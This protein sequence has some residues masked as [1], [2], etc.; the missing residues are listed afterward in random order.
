MGSTPCPQSLLSGRAL[1][2]HFHRPRH[3]ETTREKSSVHIKPF[4]RDGRYRRAARGPRTQQHPPSR[5]HP[6]LTRLAFVL[7][8]A[9]LCASDLAQAP[10][11]CGMPGPASGP[12]HSLF[13]S[14]EA[15]SNGSAEG[16]RGPGWAGHR[17]RATFEMGFRSSPSAATE[18]SFEA[19]STS[20]TSSACFPHL[21]SRPPAQPRGV[22][23]TAVAAAC[24]RRLEY[25]S[26]APT[27]PEP[28]ARTRACAQQSNI[29]NSKYSC[30]SQHRE[31]LRS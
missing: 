27:D 28:P 22:P 13:C 3:L 7:P 21:S 2:A 19:V 17:A 10:C 14:P 15:G 9:T 6:E 29:K 5:P 24:L 23:K 8:D 25:H 26:R 16:V 1:L 4:G 31:D 18:F 20:R 11:L 12:V 30:K